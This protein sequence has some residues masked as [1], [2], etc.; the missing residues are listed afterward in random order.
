MWEKIKRFFK[1]SETILLARVQALA[2]LVLAAVV[3]VDPQLLATYL[4]TKY[5]PLW[6]IVSGVLTEY[7]RRRRA[8]DLQ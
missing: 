4:P 2:G 5:V 7:A 1:H 6:L 3:A 8:E